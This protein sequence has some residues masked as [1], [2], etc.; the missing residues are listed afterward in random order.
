MSGSAT[1]LVRLQEWYRSQCDGDW[2][3]SYGVKIET[4]D[5]P[6]W[7]VTIDLTDTAW[8]RLSRPQEIVQRSDADWVQSEIAEGKFV[9][10]GGVGNLEEVLELFLDAVR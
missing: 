6:G 10:C 2:E 3:H 1:A 7:L 5:N 9:G 4:L 8:E